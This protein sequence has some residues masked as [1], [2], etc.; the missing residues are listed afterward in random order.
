MVG[1]IP[2][3]SAWMIA[4]GYFDPGNWATDLEAGTQFGY[5]L[6]W[7]M[8]VANGMAI[9][10]QHLCLRLAV[11][12]GRDLAEVSSLLDRKKN[13]DADDDDDQG[14][15]DEE[16]LE[17]QRHSETPSKRSSDRK[18]WLWFVLN[19]LM[20][21]T[22]EAAMIATDL[23]QLMG[24][25][26]AVRML[27][28]WMPLPVGC[29][30]AALD[31]F[32]VFFVLNQEADNYGNGNY[33]ELCNRLLEW[34]VAALMAF[35]TVCVG[36]ELILLRRYIRLADLF[37]GL[38]VPR[39]SNK[40]AL[41]TT[42]GLI[43]ATVMPHNL[44][45]HSALAKR[46]FHSASS[47]TSTD[48]ASGTTTTGTNASVPKDGNI[49][50][51]AQNGDVTT[52]SEPAA[53][54]DDRS[55]INGAE[56]TNT[57]E[58]KRRRGRF[59]RSKTRDIAVALM[60]AVFVNGGILVLAA[61]ATDSLA[62]DTGAVNAPLDGLESVARLLRRT[63]GAAAGILYALGLLASGISATIAGT[64]SGQAV[65]EGFFL[66]TTTTTTSSSHTAK[67]KDN[68]NRT[69]EGKGWLKRWRTMI[70]RAVTLLLALVIASTMASLAD[71]VLFYSQV[72]LSL[73]LPLAIV[74]LI[75]HSQ[76]TLGLAG[77]L[78][79]WSIAGTVLLMNGTYCVLSVT[80]RR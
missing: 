60:L 80:G 14:D 29:F 73:Q 56:S 59:I 77:R 57:M 51:H 55:S 20:Y 16:D 45:L 48:A 69:L 13:D 78:V 38:L 79:A 11:H 7:V 67:Q 22:I 64:L 26:L 12:G 75:W 8:L 71:D 50:D 25:A 40:S 23:A 4:V 66:T 27:F 1:S 31:V 44:Y 5:S 62:S 32:I 54:D 10:L 70:I 49:D 9:F 18:R 15:G 46:E 19:L 52:T 28:P 41:L 2:L 43:G 30:L 6:L 76:M 37:S 61:A 42:M 47:T 53:G 63:I 72:A 68:N 39:L 24:S 65:I 36:V 33:G 3:G 35:V 34:F 21:G 74:P 17:G 58:E